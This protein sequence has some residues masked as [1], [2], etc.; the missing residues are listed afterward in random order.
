MGNAAGVELDDGAQE[1]EAHAGDLAQ[2]EGLAPQVPR[3]RPSTAPLEHE[4]ERH[5]APG[6]PGGPAAALALAAFAFAAPVPGG[7]PESGEVER[8]GGLVEAG[9]ARAAAALGELVA[10]T[11]ADGRRSLVLCDAVKGQDVGVVQGLRERG[12]RRGVKVKSRRGG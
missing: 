1:L 9:G 4:V 3:Q 11:V 8:G 5:R 7:I 2:G 10:A 6:G 12:P